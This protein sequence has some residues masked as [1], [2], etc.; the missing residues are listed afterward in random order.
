MMLSIKCVCVCHNGDHTRVLKV[1]LRKFIIEDMKNADSKYA[2]LDKNDRLV[3]VKPP[4]LAFY[5]LQKSQGEGENNRATK[6][7]SLADDMESMLAKLETNASTPQGKRP[8]AKA[9][10]GASPAGAAAEGATEASSEAAAEAATQA[11]AAGAKAAPP[12]P[13][14][15]AQQTA[16]PLDNLQALLRQWG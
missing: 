10:A 3:A 5:E 8:K 9:K 13:P 2:P 11:T 4:R 6:R 15:A 12:Q 1:I 14:A 16:A 7:A